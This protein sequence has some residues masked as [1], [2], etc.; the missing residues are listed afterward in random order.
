MA[1]DSSRTRRQTPLPLTKNVFSETKLTYGLKLNG[2]RT[3]TVI[4][5]V[6]AAYAALG[7]QLSTYTALPGWLRALLVI[8]GVAAAA[9]NERV[10][11]GVSNPDVRAEAA[12]KDDKPRGY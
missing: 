7:P 9:L 10:Q 3:V 5:A 11:G 6:A 8:A 12:L 2:S 4:G 1:L